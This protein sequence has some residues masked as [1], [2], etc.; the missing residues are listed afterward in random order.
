MKDRNGKISS[1]DIVNGRV[2]SSN[3]GLSYLY[4]PENLDKSENSNTSNDLS[5]D[6]YNH[7]LLGHCSLDVGFQVIVCT[8]SSIIE[9]YLDK[10]IIKRGN[11][12]PGQLT[13]EQH[14]QDVSCGDDNAWHQGHGQ[15]VLVKLLWYP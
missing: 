7:L 11:Q 8:C 14:Q 3:M 13:Q 6:P 12:L 5:D 10:S 1:A 15:A 2:S 4:C 9:S